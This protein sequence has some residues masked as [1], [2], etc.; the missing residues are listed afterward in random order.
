M[1]NRTVADLVISGATV[2][3]EDASFVA[4]VA[5]KDG[6]ILAIG[7]ERAMPSARETFHATG[8]HLLPGAIDVHVHF[9]EP[10]YTDKEVWQTATAAA[11]VAGVT[12]VFELTNVDPPT[13]T[14]DRV[15]LR[16]AAPT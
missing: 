9:R 7:E 2:V 14:P 6:K 5:I 13:Q 16:A 3:T 11:A 8:L 12:T 1:T 15:L 4:A 10:G